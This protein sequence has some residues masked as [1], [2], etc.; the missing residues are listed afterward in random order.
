M[1]TRD[2]T[3]RILRDNLPR[4]KTEYGL[5]RLALFGSAARDT[6]T[7]DSDID[8]IAEFDRPIGIRFVEFADYL[9][10]LLGTKT[11]ILT[12]AGVDGIRN[13][14]VAEDIRESAVYV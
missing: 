2:E 11:D 9:E 8:L 5:K 6:Q 12:P 14:R 4:L 10:A 3:L 13:A 7:E 1:R